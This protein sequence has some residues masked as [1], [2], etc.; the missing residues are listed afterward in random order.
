M[1][2]KKDILLRFLKGHSVAGEFANDELILNINKDSIKILTVS[3]GKH[4][5][6]SGIL[7]GTFEDIGEVALDKISNL[8]SL[9]SNFSSDTI[10]ISKKENKLVL[11]SVF[12]KI[13][14]TFTLK[15]PEYVVNKI[16]EKKFDELCEKADGNRFILSEKMVD[17]IITTVNSVKADNISLKLKDELLTIEV[18]NGAQS[19]EVSFN[20]KES[21][22]ATSIKLNKAIVDVLKML[23]GD[24][25][26]SVNTDSPIMFGVNN[27][28]YNIIY[29]VATLKK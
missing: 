24:V 16:T 6:V 7:K 25:D 2:I 3:N 19:I 15:N 9:I 28:D 12:D 14:S 17:K 10:S 1:V 26:V 23:E 29:I 4:V 5:V 18:D 11:E 8:I 22:K 20:L 13:K 21:V 27:K